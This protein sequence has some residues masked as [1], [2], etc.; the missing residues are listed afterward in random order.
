[1]KSTKNAARIMGN[2]GLDA[3]QR[4]RKNLVSVCR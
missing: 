4:A 1:M 3:S 2:M